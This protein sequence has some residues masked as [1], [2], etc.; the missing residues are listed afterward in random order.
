[1]FSQL[2]AFM[3]IGHLLIQVFKKVLATKNV[4]KDKM[5]E[6]VDIP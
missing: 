2:P 5:T 6:R 1:M 3:K 4:I